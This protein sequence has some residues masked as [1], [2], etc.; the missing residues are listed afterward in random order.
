M[1]TLIGILLLVVTA[2][3]HRGM[4][5]I[6]TAVV[7]GW[8]RRTKFLPIA[9]FILLGLIHLVHIVA[10][11]LMYVWLH[12]NLWPEAFGGAFQGKWNDYYYYSGLNFATLG[13]TNMSVIGPM[14]I[15]AMIHSLLGFMVLT[16][17]ASYLYGT[18]RVQFTEES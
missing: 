2:F 13:Q 10:G 12:A 1:A 9:V 18:C 17:S 5:V 8:V 11:G 6:A 7:P 4:L 15:V 14:R 3:A 16:W